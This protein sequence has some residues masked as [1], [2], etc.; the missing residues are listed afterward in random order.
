[1]DK[2][3]FTEKSPGKLIK[4]HIEN[5]E[6]WAFIPDPLPNSWNVPNELWPLLAQARE[7][8]A[9]L[10]GIG[11][12]MPNYNLLLKPLQQR[13]AL[14]SSS[15]EGTYA[16][17]EQ[18]LL[19]EINPKEPKSQFDEANEWKEV[20]NY[21]EALRFGQ[22]ALKNIPV[23]LR[24]LR[25]LHET[26]LTGV[27]GHHRDPGNF[28]RTQVHVGS[29]RR[30]IPPP[31]G[32]AIECLYQLEKYIH[33]DNRIDPLIFCFIV[34][35]QFE[36][37]HPF[38]DGNGRVGRLLLSLMIYQWCK[39]NAPWLYLSPFFD[40][41]KN[42]Y[43][44]NLFEISTKGNWNNWIAFCLRATVSQAKDAI[45]RFDRLVALK[46]KYLKIISDH[47]GNIRVYKLVEDLF[48]APAITI[49]QVTK[50]F[51]I[52]FPTAK[53]D[54]ELL[55]EVQ[56]LIPGQRISRSKVFFAPEIIN[57]ALRDFEE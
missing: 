20:S 31:S 56:I 57:V 4:V 49:P 24:L 29:D 18:L 51:E 12:H 15:L 50:M 23:S 46:E 6:D 2:S 43:I 14:K 5:E 30:F 16:T 44:N 48:N 35:Y 11:R 53:N 34:H 17:P 47:G 13:E 3:L 22:E 40:R 45:K 10:D 52:T 21:N 25:A 28:R 33:Q 8:L 27:R 7:E 37:I 41:Y 9:R 36:T 26:L 54:I 32:E 55:V 19:F 1:M 39:L 38:L 42:E